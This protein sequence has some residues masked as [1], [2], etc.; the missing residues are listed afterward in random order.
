MTQ[1][2]VEWKGRTFLLHDLTAGDK[3]AFC[4]WATRWN[5]MKQI[6]AWGH[7]P[8]I[9]NPLLADIPPLV[10]WGDRGPS[11]LVAKTLSHPEGDLQL[12]KLLFRDSIRGLSDVDLRAMIKAKT[13]E[14]NEA[15]EKAGREATA[16][17]YAPANDY[18]F[19]MKMIQESSD[20]KVPTPGTGTDP[21]GSTAS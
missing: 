9:L 2:P 18:F 4:K 11:P 21:P 3:D 6:E 15:N 7:V 19:A 8:G 17:D 13:D 16:E 5:G 10:F 14:Q 1:Y 20:P 12:N